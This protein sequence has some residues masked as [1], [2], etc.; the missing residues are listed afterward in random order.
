MIVKGSAVKIKKLTPLDAVPFRHLMLEGCRSSVTDVGMMADEWGGE[1]TLSVLVEKFHSVWSEPD[2]FILGAWME[3]KLL[4]TLGFSRGNRV[5]SQHYAMLWAM[6]V[7]KDYRG[8][9]IART[10]LKEIIKESRGMRGLEML[11]LKVRSNNEPACR[12]YRSVGFKAVGTEP[13]V[14]KLGNEYIDQTWM[15]RELTDIHKTS[16]EENE[17]IHGKSR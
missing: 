6:H 3:G 7:D 15:V 12:V 1:N 5:M 14:M 11:R 2:H 16:S 13:K 8:L 4:G 10:L 17:A 9:G